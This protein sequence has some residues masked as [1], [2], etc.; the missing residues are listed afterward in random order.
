MQIVFISQAIHLHQLFA[1]GMEMEL[2]NARA[3]KQQA[4][5]GLSPQAL[6]RER[7]NW[8]TPF[9]FVFIFYTL[10]LKRF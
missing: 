10:A 3:V 8:I 5:T 6:L 9:F 2:L 1:S 7:F 4:L